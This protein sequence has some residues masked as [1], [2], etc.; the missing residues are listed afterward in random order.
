MWQ[1][2]GDWN[3]WS[4]WQHTGCKFE[5]RASLWQVKQPLEENGIHR[6]KWEINHDACSTPPPTPATMVVG[7]ISYPGIGIVGLG[8]RA[9]RFHCSIMR[10]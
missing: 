4:E 1:L 2:T 7:Y 5:R 9:G 6:A 8:I 3:E 10:V